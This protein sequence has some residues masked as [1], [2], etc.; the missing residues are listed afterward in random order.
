MIAFLNALAADLASN[1][2]GWSDKILYLT[3]CLAICKK[4]II[5]MIRVPFVEATIYPEQTW[6]NIIC[7]AAHKYKIEEHFNRIL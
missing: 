2:M 4:S 3:I 1:S 7:R 6:S 5:I